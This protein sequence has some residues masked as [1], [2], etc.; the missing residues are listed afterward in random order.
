M[1]E[2]SFLGV[3]EGVQVESQEWIVTVD[4]SNRA[5]FFPFVQTPF[6]GNWLC[7]PSFFRPPSQP[8]S[9]P[10]A[11]ASADRLPSYILKLKLQIILVTIRVRIHDKSM[12]THIII[13]YPFSISIH[14]SGQGANTGFCIHYT[15]LKH[16]YKKKD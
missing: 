9:L 14:R 7:I 15:S 13:H 11:K 6:L 2:K 1:F 8:I 3:K 5:H 12:S 10:D 4:I 16:N